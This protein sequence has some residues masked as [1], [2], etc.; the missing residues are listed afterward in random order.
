M[1]SLVFGPF[2]HCQRSIQE[3][4]WLESAS[5]LVCEPVHVIPFFSAT[6]PETTWGHF[7]WHCSGCCCTVLRHWE[8]TLLNTSTWMSLAPWP[9]EMMTSTRCSFW[10]SV[11]QRWHFWTMIQ[12][13]RPFQK[14]A[15][16]MFFG[17][18][19]RRSWE[20]VLTQGRAQL[21]KVFED[22]Q[23]WWVWGGSQAPAADDV[24]FGFQRPTGKNWEGK[25]LE[26]KHQACYI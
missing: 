13:S 15:V 25:E 1:F 9:S 3:A 11:T 12:W 7:R 24:G 5:P 4:I 16:L 2:K 23:R 6:V 18:A 17:A 19:H 10:V 20:I 8:M 21:K 26:E 14:P 22:A